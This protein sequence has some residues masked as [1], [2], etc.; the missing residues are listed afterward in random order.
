M[1]AR[2]LGIVGLL[3]SASVAQDTPASAKSKWENLVPQI[4]NVLSKEG[5]TCPGQPLHI[6]IKD[7]EQLA[8]NSVALVYFCPGG[9]YT[10]WIVA[11][12]L[13]GDQPVPAHFHTENGKAADIGFAE[14]ASVMHG[15]DAKLVPEENAIHG[16]EWDNDETMRLKRCVVKAYVWNARAK[17]FDLSPALSRRAKVSYCGALQ[18]KLLKQH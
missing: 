3:A 15:M 8:G 18:K 17:T 1:T 11:M 7:A 12:R 14:G 13:E 2:F 16:I 9:A 4:E 6:G 10:N 5:T